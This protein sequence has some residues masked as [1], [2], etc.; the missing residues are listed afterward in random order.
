MDEQAVMPSISLMEDL[1]Q[2]HVRGPADVSDS[3][4]TVG[5]GTSADDLAIRCPSRESSTF[6]FAMAGD[7]ASGLDLSAH[8]PADPPRRRIA[9]RTVFRANALKATAAELNFEGWLCQRGFGRF[10]T[11]L[12]A[13]GSDNAL[14][15]RDGPP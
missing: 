2:P 10:L 7:R 9:L 6:S 11:R 13:P 15:R 12:H 14:S 5:G 3:R 4:W 8:I 1:D